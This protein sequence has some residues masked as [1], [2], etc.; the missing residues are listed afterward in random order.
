MISAFS[1]GKNRDRSRGFQATDLVNLR[2][3]T[4]TKP[5]SLRAAWRLLITSDLD[6]KRLDPAT[7]HNQ[8]RTAEGI[9]RPPV[10][11]GEPLTFGDV[12]VADLQRKHIKAS[13]EAIRN[14]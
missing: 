2:R 4:A 10:V 14:A 12:L 7:Q 11:E 6:W 13:R 9:L 5:K 1:S 8:T 3:M